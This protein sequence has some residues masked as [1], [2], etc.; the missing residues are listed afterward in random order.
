MTY[1]CR[2]CW[3]NA[4][5]AHDCVLE[6]LRKSK[7]PEGREELDALRR[8]AYEH[9]AGQRESA[10]NTEAFHQAQKAGA[11]YM[12]VACIREGPKDTLALS[13][14]RKFCRDRDSLYL[15]LLGPSRVGKTVAATLCAVEFARRWDWNGQSTGSNSEPLRY[16]DASTISALSSFDR[17]SQRLYDSLLAARL[18][19]MEEC[20][21]EG[22]EWGRGRV[23]DLLLKREAA[24]RRTVLTGNL[25]PEAFRKRYGDAVANRINETGY[26]PNLWAEKPMTKVRAA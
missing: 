6:S 14:A 8:S 13:D 23:T 9:A 15:L 22:T 24:R 20:G 16:V 25:R 3:R 4:G 12:A 2:D 7:T 17:E 26:A 19:V 11:P 18:L 10:T 1:L 21:N 5:P